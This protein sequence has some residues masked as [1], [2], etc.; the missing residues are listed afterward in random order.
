MPA[1]RLFFFCV[2]NI[3]EVNVE[4]TPSFLVHSSHFSSAQNPFPFPFKCL[5]QRLVTIEEAVC[6]LASLAV[7]LSISQISNQIHDTLKLT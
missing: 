2:I 7:F 6:C 3:Y 1:R 5:L 4:I